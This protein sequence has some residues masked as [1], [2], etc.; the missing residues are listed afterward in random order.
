MIMVWTT[1]LLIHVWNRKVELFQNNK[2]NNKRNR[3]FRRHK[4]LKPNR[5]FQSPKRLKSNQ[6]IQYLQYQR[7]RRFLPNKKRQKSNRLWGPI[8]HLDLLVKLPKVHSKLNQNRPHHRRSHHHSNLSRKT[9]KMS[10]TEKRILINHRRLL[11]RLQGLVTNRWRLV[12]P[13]RNPLSRNLISVLRHHWMRL[14][15]NH[16]PPLLIRMMCIQHC[17]RNGRSQ[18]LHLHLLTPGRLLRRQAGNLRSLQ[19][20]HRLQRE[21]TTLLA[22]VRLGQLLM[23]SQMNLQ[24]TRPLSTVTLLVQRVR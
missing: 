16:L 11:S 2:R 24:Q 1:S 17:V 6:K 12:H 19:P 5:P 13:L 22:R 20:R 7:P 21:T 15:Q 18:P 10:M 8:R 14:H 3:R 4:H 9:T 23:Q